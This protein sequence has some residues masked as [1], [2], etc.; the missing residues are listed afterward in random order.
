MPFSIQLLPFS[1]TGTA[2]EVTVEISKNSDLLTLL[3]TIKKFQI[4]KPVTL[5]DFQI[6]NNLRTDE[7]WKHTCFEIFIG[8]EDSDEY[9]EFNFSTSGKWNCYHF[10]NYRKEM[11][12]EPDTALLMFSA[13]QDNQDA[14]FNIKVKLPKNLA[15]KNKLLSSPAV[16]VESI[17]NG[18]RN[19]EYYASSHKNNK[20]DFH[21]KD[22]RTVIIRQ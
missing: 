17:Q 2:S 12:Q 20:P 13:I 4:E 10:D 15:N 3:Y 14:L 7:L 16:I 8:T 11:T 5:S 1:K 19:F 18:M 9:W 6:S 22:A 21:R